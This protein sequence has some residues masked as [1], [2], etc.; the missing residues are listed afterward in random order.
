MPDHPLDEIL[1]AEPSVVIAEPPGDHDL[2]VRKPRARK[3]SPFRDAIEHVGR[4]EVDRERSVRTLGGSIEG[5]RAIDVLAGPGHEDTALGP[6]EQLRK[7]ILDIVL[8]LCRL[9][10]SEVCSLGQKHVDVRWRMSHHPI[11][12]RRLAAMSTEV[13]SIKQSSPRSFDQQHVCIKGGVVGENR[14]DG[15]RPDRE[16]SRAAVPGFKP[17]GKRTARNVAGDC[18][19]FRRARPRPDRPRGRQFL[20]KSPMVLVW[21]AD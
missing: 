18:D 17:P 11:N 15:K 9:V 10:R 8:A 16:R 2:Q 5:H 7:V 12:K 21:M 6:A 1:A 14:R 19:Q 13:T 4:V 20:N 3:A